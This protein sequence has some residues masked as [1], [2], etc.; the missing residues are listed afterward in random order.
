MKT[1]TVTVPTVGY[2][3]YEVQA[4]SAEE[5]RKILTVASELE[6][7]F[8]PNVTFVGQCAGAWVKNADWTIRTIRE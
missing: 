5:A 7:M 1:Y 8:C 2:I 6:T 3:V 4:T